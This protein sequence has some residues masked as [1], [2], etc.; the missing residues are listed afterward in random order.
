MMESDFEVES[1]IEEGLEIFVLA[2]EPSMND[3]KNKGSFVM[4][5]KTRNFSHKHRIQKR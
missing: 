2:G 5:N 4:T 1:G 3:G